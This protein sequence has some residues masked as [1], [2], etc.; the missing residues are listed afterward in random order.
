MAD[1]AGELWLLLIQLSGKV[2]R[3]EECMPRIRT[4]EKREMIDDFIESGERLTKKLERLLSMAETPL[5]KAGE[6]I[7]LGKNTGIE[8]ANSLFGDERHLD[9][10][11]KIMASVRLWNLRFDTNCEDIL[12]RPGQ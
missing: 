7:G 8:V 12:R 1:Y 10:T 5:F 2:K 9:K 4:Q 6:E 3:A 11:E